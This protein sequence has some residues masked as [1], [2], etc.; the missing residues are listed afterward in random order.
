MA[1]EKDEFRDALEAVRRGSPE[2]IWDFIEEYGPH[3]QRIA[4][5]Y[6]DTRM[7]SKFD[8]VDFVQMV[9]A[10]FFR[11]PREIRSFCHPDELTR[12]LGRLVR[13]K[14]CDEHRRRLF[15]A[16][17]DVTRERPLH[18]SD[19]VADRIDVTPSQVAIARE[20]WE[21]LLEGQPQPVQDIA[22]LRLGGSTFVEIGRQ[23]Q[24]NERSVRRAIER[25]LNSYRGRSPFLETTD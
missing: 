2:A 9:W 10:S 16:K 25:L 22:R 7:Q 17:R 21:R 18:A 5:R 6:L 13:N 4:R 12:Y 23:L 19:D 1:D 15:T 8:S 3:I 20:E 11:D 24:M 14:V